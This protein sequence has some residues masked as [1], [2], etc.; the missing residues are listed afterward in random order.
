MSSTYSLNDLLAQESQLQ[1]T[2]FNNQIAWALGCKLKQLA[3]K[4]EAQVTI[5]VYAFNQCLFSYAMPGTQPDNL[6]WIKRKR[7]TVLRFGHSSYYIGQYNS[8]KHRVFEQQDHI[9][10]DLYCAHGGAFPIIIKNSGVVG[11]VT[12]S[13]LPQEQDH[14]LIVDTLA[15]LVESY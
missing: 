7:Q 4:R 8:A 5:E 1:F 3:E 9:D 15:E 2:F 6:H 11:V 14:Q 13:G 12:V 10:A